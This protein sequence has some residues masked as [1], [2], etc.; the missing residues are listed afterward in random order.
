MGS[1]GSVLQNPE[2]DRA[3]V[4]ELTVCLKPG[5]QIAD[6]GYH[7]EDREFTRALVESF[8]KVFKEAPR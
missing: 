1:P 5:I 8:D 7:P 2:E 6:P 4:D 3:F